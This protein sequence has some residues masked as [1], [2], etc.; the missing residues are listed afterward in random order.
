[1][2]QRRNQQQRSFQQTTGNPMPQGT[3]RPSAMSYGGTIWGNNHPSL[4]SRGTA[5]LFDNP[6]Q[7][8]HAYARSIPDNGDTSNHTGGWPSHSNSR[9]PSS[10]P[11]RTRGGA[12]N[13]D[14]NIINN[15]FSQLG[16]GIP[17]DRNNSINHAATRGTSSRMSPPGLSHTPS[18]ST[19]S[20]R[21]MPGY[22]QPRHGQ[23]ASQQG[24]SQQVLNQQVLNQQLLNQQ[25]LAQQAINQQAFG[26]NNAHSLDEQPVQ[27]QFLSNNRA[28]F[29][30]DPTSQIWN[31]SNTANHA[32]SSSRAGSIDIP[33]MYSQPNRLASNRMTQGSSANTFMPLG[34]T[35][36][37]RDS[38]SRP[39]DSEGDRRVP[40]QQQF[41][42][43]I[44]PD[45][46]YTVYH[47]YGGYSNIES[48]VPSM[49]PVAPINNYVNPLGNLPV[50]TL[51]GQNQSRTIFDPWVADFCAA[52]KEKK[53]SFPLSHV[54]G[55][56]VLST[57]QQESSRFMQT[58]LSTAKSDE[59]ERMFNEIGSELVPL[60]RD[61]F[62][63]YVIQKLIEHGSQAQKARVI[64]AVKGHFSELCINQYG[65]RVMQKIVESCLAIQTA[66][67][68]PE[69]QETEHLK[70]LMRD[71]HANHV[72]QK[73]VSVMPPEHFR[74]ITVVCQKNARELS[75]H[76]A[77]CRVVQRVL[78]RA[79]EEDV[80]TLL[81]ELH[82]VM[83]KLITDQWGN[84][85]A[86][87][88][89]QNRGPEDRDL[90]FDR[91]MSD[92]MRLCQNKLASHVVEKCIKFGTPQQRTQ[93]RERLSPANDTEN[94]LYNMMR[95]QYGNYVVAS[96]LRYLEWGS[97]ERRQFKAEVIEKT[98][99][100]KANGSKSL[101]SVEKIFQ[102]DI[103]RENADNQARQR[104][105][106][107]GSLQVEV[108]SVVPTPVL[109]NETNSPQSDSLASTDANAIEVPSTHPKST[110]ANLRVRDI[111][112]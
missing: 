40:S 59:K 84:Y 12:D 103:E 63:N 32:S 39:L 86:G 79:D 8:K 73:I 23:T 61:L 106:T 55:H 2:S 10:S 110:G 24:L 11:N 53:H 25:L 44:L 58:K 43:Y 37:S 60:M 108:D 27:H 50:A 4:I 94:T 16:L 20:Q 111:D 36:N 64:E 66:E 42:N 18:S 29:Q 80:K 1:M 109:T 68:L 76:Q 62:G 82:L 54:F 90:I 17:D 87:H 81:R 77:S 49:P 28:S 92:L 97:E 105:A 102:A 96:L 112:A 6:V 22:T 104:A 7:E 75:T 101:N 34:G 98:N 3:Q 83:D 52:L 89:I 19:H 46:S 71:E 47:P 93:I 65:C 88:I 67:L 48:Q 9:S 99:L 14:M 21:A 35:W 91:V 51:Q 13:S 74:F 31:Q 57:G 70:S 26:L 5:I 85:V 100:L 72:I 33:S 95:D 69:I 15:Q 41:H 56:I 38:S 78:E 107:R 30:L 45:Q